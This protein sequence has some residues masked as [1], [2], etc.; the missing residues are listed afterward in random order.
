MQE[1]TEMLNSLKDVGI[2]VLILGGLIYIVL[3]VLKQYPTWREKENEGK[4]ERAK[5]YAQ[6]LENLGLQIHNQSEQIKHFGNQVEKFGDQ[7]GNQG[8]LTE[9][10]IEAMDS[11]R[12]GIS[13][14]S[15]RCIDHG[16]TLEVLK[17]RIKK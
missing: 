5:I 8:R 13:E 17:E 9:K 2:A 1:F 14:M 4:K 3:E 16:K 11:I 10:L 15:H 7:V 6:A 12:E